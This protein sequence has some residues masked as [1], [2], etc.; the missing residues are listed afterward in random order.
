MP[1]LHGKVALITGAAR[2]MGACEARVFV[3]SGARVVLTDVRE[4]GRQVAEELG[5][6]AR[7]RHHD[8][9]SE[10]DWEASVKFALAEFGRVD[11]LVNNAGVYSGA[12]LEQETLDTFERVLK[13]NLVSQFIGLRAVLDPMRT[14]GG[15]SI[16]NISSQAGLQGIAGHASYGASKWGVRG[17]SKTAAIELGRH[18]I[19]VN[20]VHPGT[21]D[22]EMMSAIGLKPGPGNFP[23][24]P[25]SRVGTVEDVAAVV[26]FLASDDSAYLTGAEIAV[27]GGAAAGSAP[28]GFKQQL[29]R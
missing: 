16:V 28:G 7:F 9:T 8:V 3:E 29:G 25:L 12:W 2:G 4:D 1:S 22:T 27:D 13:V 19:R 24:V 11:V 6:A 18:G 10:A 21:I 15:G 20:S 23:I 5:A 14:A 17:L 26:A